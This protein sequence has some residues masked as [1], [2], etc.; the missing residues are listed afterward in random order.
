MS[1]SH[2][3]VILGGEGES[4]LLELKS[5][6]EGVI[7]HKLWVEQPEGILTA[8]ATKP[9]PKKMVAQYF[10]SYKTLK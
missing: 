1:R 10:T 3:Q 9:Y 8:L 7:D 4:A 5:R 2:P 6:L